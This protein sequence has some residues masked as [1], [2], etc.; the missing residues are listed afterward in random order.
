MTQG[1]ILFAH[2]SR[3]PLWR[4]PVEA[5]AERIRQRAPGTPVACAY[6]ELCVPDMATAATNLIAANAHSIRVL[7]LF[8][9]VGKH[10]REDLPLL[11][12]ELRS[13]HPRVAITLLPAVGEHPLMLDL[14]AQLAL[15]E[16]TALA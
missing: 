2:G 10:A 12:A 8:L 6:L 9:G 11:L 3:D 1:I 14:M 4:A 7:P 15:A 5:V 16:G 13:A